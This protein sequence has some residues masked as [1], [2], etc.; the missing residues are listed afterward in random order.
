MP[1]H[2]EMLDIWMA[3][4]QE[5]GVPL[6]QMKTSNLWQALEQERKAT[7]AWAMVS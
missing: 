7:L 3:W 2:A 1:A 4:E 6:V 5:Q